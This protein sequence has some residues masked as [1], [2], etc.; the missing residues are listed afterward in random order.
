MHVLMVGMEWFPNRAGGLSRYFY[1]EVHA[2]AASKIGGTAIVTDLRAGQEAPAPFTLR[3]MAQE[4]A[5]THARRNGVRRLVR[6]ELRDATNRYDVVNPHFALYAQPWLRYLPA[7]IPMVCNFQ[8]PWALEMAAEAAN[9]GAHRGGLKR[10]LKNS[11]RHKL[12]LL[13][14]RRI[15]LAV[16]GRATRLITL[17]QAFANLAQAQYGVAPERLRVIP[18]A[19]DTAL[20]MQAPARDV[21]REQ[22]GWPLDRPILISVRRLAHRMGLENLLDAVTLVKRWHPDI[23]LMIGGKGALAASLSAQI[24]RMELQDNVRMLGFV[25]D[26]QLPLAY[27]AADL[28]LVPTVALEGFGLVT[29][30][31]LAS[32]TPVLGTDIGGTP[33]ILRGLHPD[34]IFVAPTPEAMAEKIHAALTGHLTLPDRDACR[35]YAHR[36]DW[37]NVIPHILKTYKEN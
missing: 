26:A 14:A 17:S 3:A 2:L 18:G 30:E 22:L 16:Y 12:R 8:G 4:G 29:V 20:Y 35:A 10:G 6:E 33:E 15:E 27:A 21:A 13:V 25:P 1:E 19:I 36:Y 34:L 9:S 23:L 28:T 37:Q 5:G 7:S 31:S 11:W 24:T 32:G